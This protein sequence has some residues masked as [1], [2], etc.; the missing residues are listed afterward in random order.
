[1]DPCV[2]DEIAA[3]IKRAPAEDARKISF[4]TELFTSI[5]LLRKGRITE[6]DVFEG[7]MQE[8]GG[9]ML[10]AVV[11]IT[12]GKGRGKEEHTAFLERTDDGKL[13]ITMPQK[14]LG[15]III[16]QVA[17]NEDEQ[18]IAEEVKALVLPRKYGDFQER[19][20]YFLTVEGAKLS[21]KKLGKEVLRTFI[22][23]AV[24]SRRNAQGLRR[25]S[26]S[27]VMAK[28]RE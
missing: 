12:E 17:L 24:P 25:T 26:R 5:A 11:G 20:D 18:L 7:L 4:L 9:K 21:K 6:K 28:L 1:M 23:H 16:V 13:L 14:Q 3:A 22:A 8:G 15:G 27:R 10:H 2:H 19:K